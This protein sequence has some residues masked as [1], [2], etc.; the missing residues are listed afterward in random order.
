MYKLSF[1]IWIC[2]VCMLQ[3]RVERQV[4]RVKLNPILNRLDQAD[5]AT[6]PIWKSVGLQRHCNSID[7]KSVGLQRTSTIYRS[8]RI[9]LW[10]RIRLDQR[11]LLVLPLWYLLMSLIYLKCTLNFIDRLWLISLLTKFLLYFL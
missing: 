10:T 8:N 6:W 11:I 3:C 9:H 2:N 1:L 5:V 4:G 7:L